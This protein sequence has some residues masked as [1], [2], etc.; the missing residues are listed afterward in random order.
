MG[1]ALVTPSTLEGLRTRSNDAGCRLRIW[2]HPGESSSCSLSAECANHIA[3][4]TPTKPNKRPTIHHQESVTLHLWRWK[5]SFFIPKPSPQICFLTHST[6]F[7]RHPSPHTKWRNCVVIRIEFFSSRKLLCVW[8]GGGSGV[9]EGNVKPEF[10]WICPKMKIAA[11]DKR[12]GVSGLGLQNKERE[13]ENWFVWGR[14]WEREW[15]DGG[16]NGGK[17]EVEN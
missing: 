17:G 7:R 13:D 8:D 11:G 16:V 6:G 2:F 12:E 4:A 10:M 5:G 14:G 15:K 3:T 1:L 9:T